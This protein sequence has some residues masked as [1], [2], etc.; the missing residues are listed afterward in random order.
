MRI[1]MIGTGYVGLAG[2]CLAELGHTV[3]CID[4][5]QGKIE[6]L[7]SGDIPTFEPGL[8]ELIASNIGAGRLHFSVDMAEI[9]KPDPI[10]DFILRKSARL[11]RLS[12]FLEKRLTLNRGQFWGAG[13]SGVEFE[14][15]VRL[16]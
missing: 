7:L 9:V 11:Q 2:T 10:F 14:C 1:C 5:D 16:A 4:K 13:H 3:I 15:K 6:R 8:K 12:P